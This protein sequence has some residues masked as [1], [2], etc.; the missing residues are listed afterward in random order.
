MMTSHRRNGHSSTVP[1]GP[2][3]ADAL[4]LVVLLVT[5]I[6][7]AQTVLTSSNCILEV[8]GSIIWR[9]LCADQLP[10]LFS[11]DIHV[12]EDETLQINIVKHSIS[13]SFRSGHR[14]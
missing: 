12:S 7:T 11:T 5:S 14:F 2:C 9:S 13:Q 10:T 8:V 1:S 3:H 4:Q 6:E